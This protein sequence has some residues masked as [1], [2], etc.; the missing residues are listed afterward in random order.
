MNIK[1]QWFLQEQ[2][3]SNTKIE[4]NILKRMYTNDFVA[5]FTNTL[6][7]KLMGLFD[8]MTQDIAIDLGTANTLIIHNDKVVVDQPS[9]VLLTEK[10]KK[11]LLLEKGTTD[12]WNLMKESRQYVHLK[13]V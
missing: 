7:E 9:I 10:L 8:F 1:W 3:T 2:G 11:L 5:Y 6:K 4:Y 12:A 13:T